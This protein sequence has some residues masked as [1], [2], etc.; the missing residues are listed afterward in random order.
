MHFLLKY[1]DTRKAAINALEDYALMEQIIENTP[2]HTKQLENDLTALSSPKMDGMPKT[3]DPKAGEAR[4]V[5]TLSEIDLAWERYKEAKAYMDWFLP[6]WAVLSDDERYVL[7]TY[8]LTNGSKEDAIGQIMERFYIERTSAHDK[9]S[10]ALRHL[11]SALYG[12]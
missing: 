5:N 8:F 3:R 12:K 11:A 7:E 9:K 2:E 1:I 4:I 6:A 10:R